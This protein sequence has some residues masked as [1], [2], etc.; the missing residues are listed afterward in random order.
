M[1]LVGGKFAYRKQKEL[2]LSTPHLFLQIRTITRFCIKLIQI[3]ANTR[4]IFDLLGMHM[5]LAKA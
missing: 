4:H 5:L 2:A 1:I 3:Y